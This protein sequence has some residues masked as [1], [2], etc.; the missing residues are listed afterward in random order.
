METK[1]IGNKQALKEEE[2]VP[3]LPDQNL[4]FYHLIC[5]LYFSI[6]HISLCLF[7]AAFAFSPLSSFPFDV[8]MFFFFF[9]HSPMMELNFA[10]F[11]LNTFENFYQVFT[12]KRILTFLIFLREKAFLPLICDSQ[13]KRKLRFFEF[14]IVVI[15][16]FWYS[17]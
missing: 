14:D 6:G 10:P 17:F 11:R 1:A 3:L 7:L 15:V 16:Y 5:S 8:T 12:R 2:V 4:E 13:F 9:P